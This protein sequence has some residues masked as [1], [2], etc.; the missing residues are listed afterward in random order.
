MP[1]ACT[2]P[3]QADELL[4]LLKDRES[5]TTTNKSLH[6]QASMSMNLHV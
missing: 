2:W 3:L 6:D 5:L 4:Q 1:D